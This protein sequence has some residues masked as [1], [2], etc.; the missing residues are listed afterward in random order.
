MCAKK[1]HTSSRDFL[2]YLK[3][4]LSKQERHELERGLEADLFEKEAMEGLENITAGEAEEDLLHLHAALEKR[5]RRRKRRAW[6]SIAATAASILIVGTIFLNIYDLNPEDAGNEPLT[7]KTFR[8]L[9][10]EEAVEEMSEV[11]PEKTSQKST[12]RAKSQPP[13]EKEE[14]VDKAPETPKAPPPSQSEPKADMQEEKQDLVVLEFAADEEVKLEAIDVAEAG[15]LAEAESEAPVVAMEAAAMKKSTEQV[16]A[17]QV[18]GIVLS[19]EDMDPLP[20]A[21]IVIRGTNSGTVTDMEG[22]FTLPAD[23][24]QTAVIA[25]FVGMETKEYNLESETENQLVMQPNAQTLDEVVIV[26]QGYAR[27]YETTSNSTITINQEETA[28]S[29]TPAEPLEGYRALKKY[30]EQNMEFPGDYTPGERKVVILRF[31]VLANGSISNI[32][33]LRTP[34]EAYTLE[35]IRLIMEGPEWTP[36]RI[37]SGPIDEQVRIRIVFKK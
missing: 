32:E 24:S 11:V 35:A 27:E 34:G 21:S 9:E 23:D 37:T 12:P 28:P 15:I 20:G 16:F 17:G 1:R 7:E 36:A 33:T 18:S 3:D 8:S 10:S 14:P 26:A 2:Q 19:S 22:R 30:M 4:D 5:T 25:S 29:Y 13:D 31:T 6:Y